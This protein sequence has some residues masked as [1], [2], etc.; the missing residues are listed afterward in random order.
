MIS[1]LVWRWIVAPAF[2]LPIGWDVN[3]GI[4]AIFTVVSIIR[5]YVWRRFFN[6]GIN[7]LVLRV[8]R[9]A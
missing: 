1:L 6:A 2:G 5:S 8:F 4:T 7:R 9:G 3:L